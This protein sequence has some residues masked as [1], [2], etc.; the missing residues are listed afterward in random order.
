VPYLSR[1]EVRRRWRSWLAL[2][3]LVTLG[4]GVE[5]AGAALPAVAVSR[6]QPEELLG[7]Q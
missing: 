7:T 2:A 3:V 5:P 1:A 6:C 4:G